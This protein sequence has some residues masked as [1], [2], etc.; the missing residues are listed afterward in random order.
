MSQ[1]CSPEEHHAGQPARPQSSAHRRAMMQLWVPQE[2]PQEPRS[3][4]GRVRGTE[5]GCILSGEIQR[6]MARDWKGQWS[7]T[8]QGQKDWDQ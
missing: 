7:Q 6:A 8:L 1:H 4:G 2:G 5:E 3:L